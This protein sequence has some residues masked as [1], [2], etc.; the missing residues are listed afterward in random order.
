MLYEVITLI[1][2]TF[3]I[4]CKTWY[5]YKKVVLNWNETR[6][7]YPQNSSLVE[8]FEEQVRQNPGAT[9]LIFENEKSISRRITSYNVCY[10]KLLR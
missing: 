2:G 8:V 1:S 5:K 3:S 7:D 4:D 6:S 10:T 9:A